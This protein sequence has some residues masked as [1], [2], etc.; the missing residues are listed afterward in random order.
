MFHDQP[1]DTDLELAALEGWM[2]CWSSLME[3]RHPREFPPD[4]DEPDHWHRL[5]GSD[6]TAETFTLTA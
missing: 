4:P 2:R 6:V 1:D 5:M 3:R